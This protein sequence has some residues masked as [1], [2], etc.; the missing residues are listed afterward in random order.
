MRRLMRAGLLAS[1]LPLAYAGIALLLDAPGASAALLAIRPGPIDRPLS[2]TA[3]D[4]NRDAFDDLAI[5]NFQAGTVTILINQKNGTF[6]PQKD[7][8]FSV[9]AAT[10]ATASAG[11]LY[12]AT[13]DLNPEDV[14]GDRVSNVLDNCANVYN[15]ITTGT[16]QLDSDSN[17]VGD[18]CESVTTDSDG[19]GIP[20]FNPATDLLDNCPL[21][22]NPGQQVEDE[23][24]ADG[25]CGTE[26]DNTF[27]F[28][29]DGCGGGSLVS[30]VGAACSRSPDLAIVETSGGGLSFG[31][32]RVRVDDA[33]GGMKSRTSLQ[34]SIG[35][36]QVLL[37]DFNAD[38]FP[39]M[40]VSNS[41]TDVLLFYPGLGGGDFG[42]T[43]ILT[44]GDGPEGMASGDFDADGDRDLAVANR[45][46]GTIGL[47]ANAGTALPLTVSSTI[48]TRPGPTVLLAAPLSQGAACPAL[49]ALDQGLPVC[50]GG[51]T[52]DGALCQ[53][54][55]DCPLS[56]PG[57]GTCSSASA[58]VG[59]IEV[60]TN[61]GCVSGGSLTLTTT[62]S[63]GA[64]HRPR[65]GVFADMD[66]D[67]A[68]DLAV[69]DFTAGQVLIY[70]GDGS[71]GF[72]PAATP[73]LTGLSSPSAV[74]LLNYDP[75]T[76]P[77]PDLAVLSYASNRVDLFH[78][79]GVP[80]PSCSPGTLTFS[81]A[82]TNPASPWKNIKAMSIFPAD[83]SVGQD[84]VLLNSS[85]P[86]LD[87]MSGTG[88]TFRVLPPQSLAGVPTA[89]GMT[90]ADLRQDGALDLLVLDG[91]GNQVE[92]VTSE[93]TGLQAEGNVL[94]VGVNPVAASVAPLIVHS[95]DFDKDG[96]PDVND[97]CPTR[98]NPPGCPSHDQAG[99][100][101]C[102]LDT[103]CATQQTA[104]FTTCTNPNLAGQCDGD[105]NG[106]GDQ[107]QV[108]NAVCQSIDTDQ[109]SI[110]DYNP[111]THAVDN[112]PFVV[113]SSQLDSDGDGIGDSCDGGTCVPFT[114]VCLGGVR[115]GA[116]CV[117]GVDCDPPVNDI[118]TVNAG[119]QSPGNGTLS[120]LIG[121]ASGEFRAA[122]PSWSSVTGLSNPVGVAVGHL[123]YS[124][125]PNATFGPSCS[126]RTHN[127]LV[128]LEQG[129]AGSGDDLLAMFYGNG[130]GS[131]TPPP[132]PVTPQTALTG[133]PTRLL[134][135]PDQ[136]VC[137]NPWLSPTDPRS[138]FDKDLTT[139]VLAA[140]EPGTSS[141]GIVLPGSL[142]L[143]APPGN[144]GPLP[145]AFPPVDAQFVDLNQDDVQDL[146]VLST[147]GASTSAPNL[148]VYIGMGNG[149]F[150]TDPTL[151]PAGVPDGM[152]LLAAGNINLVS[153]ATY[154]DVA[155]FS[156]TDQAPVILTNI[157]TDRADVDGSGRVDG[158]DLAIL[159][160]SFAAE[161]GE[162]FT[163]L[164]DGTL[165][166]AGSGATRT[167]V[168]GGCSLQEGFDLPRTGSL[169]GVFQCDRVLNPMTAQNANYCV[170]TDPN[171]LNPGPALYG[172]PVDINLDGKVD[173][174][175]LA[176]L[177][178]RFGDTF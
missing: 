36:A 10:I 94:G 18:A 142:D 22:P 11:P 115:N 29:T 69:V 136:R 67:C 91:P 133:D 175:D 137:A 103:P 140:V 148:T 55:N 17:G 163:L 121:D 105:A 168:P 114:K 53:T 178:S 58:D 161:R 26:D 76:G 141:V 21:I 41:G 87:V 82:P 116:T 174:T 56:T 130:N 30:K 167:L 31:V 150:F 54:N 27:L 3:A 144:P 109:D 149:L 78:N 35:P 104:A 138:R 60:F 143:Q 1:V 159:A 164:P 146:I 38:R 89:S 83:V 171:Y 5:A 9:G 7:S 13:A 86:R 50:T 112:C 85:P 106:V 96:V 118:V 97:N 68:A 16:T 19:D 49:V 129:A 132:A 39:D 92:V 88:T 74:A 135:A 176:L 162:N 28:G 153:D 66:G 151:N 59:A 110:P 46:A 40:V 24:G 128:V 172:L 147:G 139:A 64:G 42:V 2:L 48:P 122:P 75:D 131:F 100:P 80:G 8:P 166:Q 117:T 51:S 127:D 71:G 52:R 57:F 160:R 102:F 77:A 4:F 20:D 32:T 81:A 98:Y 152:T 158:Y 107:C 14:D 6:A 156:G 124:C 72:V 113:N 90:L 154:P 99:H 37:A 44:A 134:L 84:L 145:V 95:N 34:S 62:L 73:S 23:A 120:F 108:L 70:R 93:P 43:Q 45:S 119:D 79:D 12:L 125:I 15:P 33:A 47:F 63:L 169:L 61:P 177:A 126:S 123:A 65:G 101:E 155:L 170:P 165:S 25:V 173:G 157:L 111:I